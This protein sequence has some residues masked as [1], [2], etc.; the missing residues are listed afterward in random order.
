MQ[1]IM[2][3]KSLL[4]DYT[5]SNVENSSISINSVNTRIIPFQP[6]QFSISTQFN[7]L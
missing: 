3:S 1:T 4:F 5:Q 6:I 7:S 2:L